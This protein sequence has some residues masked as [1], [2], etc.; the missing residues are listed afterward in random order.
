MSLMMAACCCGQCECPDQTCWNWYFVKYKQTYRTC[1]EFDCCGG[2]VFYYSGTYFTNSCSPPTAAAVLALF[3]AGSVIYAPAEVDIPCP[4]FDGFCEGVVTEYESCDLI[5]S[6]QQ[7][8]CTQTYS[9]PTLGPYYDQYNSYPS[10]VT[11]TA[12]RLNGNSQGPAT[13]GTADSFMQFCVNAPSCHGP[14]KATGY[15]DPNCGTDWD[16]SRYGLTII[17]PSCNENAPAGCCT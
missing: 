2:L 5:L 16:Y 8:V 6:A 3:K 10:G 9:F 13:A 14:Y 7:T 1:S 4:P 11:N 12:T 17:I 15:P